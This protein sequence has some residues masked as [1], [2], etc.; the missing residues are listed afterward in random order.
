MEWH[1]SRIDLHHSRT[2][3]RYSSQA[4]SLRR[5]LKWLKDYKLQSGRLKS[6]I[7]HHWRTHWRMSGVV[8]IASSSLQLYCSMSRSG[9]P[10]SLSRL[11]SPH[12]PQKLHHSLC[13]VKASRDFALWL[14]SFVGEL[15]SQQWQW[16]ALLMWTTFKTIA[17][18][19]V[20]ESRSRAYPV[21]LWIT[22]TLYF[23][24][25]LLFL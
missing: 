12:C 17:R 2:R 18:K 11:S 9:S 8:R 20:W 6:P 10:R 25:L 1:L 15:R 14:R 7:K 22:E 3:C 21:S 23:T 4:R 24:C 19:M 16:G 5:F 13:A